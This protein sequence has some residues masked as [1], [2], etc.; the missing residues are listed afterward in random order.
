MIFR[1]MSSP[2]TQ[3]VPLGEDSRDEILAL[4]LGIEG[5]LLL[6]Q[7]RRCTEIMYLA[8]TQEHIERL[9]LCLARIAQLRRNAGWK[10][11]PVVI[12]YPILMLHLFPIQDLQQLCM[13]CTFKRATFHVLY[14]AVGATHHS[15]LWPASR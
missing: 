3:Q 4:M 8:V 12:S 1:M 9:S 13:V 11:P 6:E 10:P 15:K 14:F 7:P 2:V 5:T